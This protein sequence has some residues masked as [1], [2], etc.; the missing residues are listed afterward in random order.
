MIIPKLKGFKINKGS[1]FQKVV[2][3]SLKNY[4]PAALAWLRF[5]FYLN[6]MYLLNKELYYTLNPD[7]DWRNFN[8]PQKSQNWKSIPSEIKI[9]STKI[10]PTKDK[11]KRYLS[12]YLLF[13]SS[14][15]QG[16]SNTP[17]DQVIQP[18]ISIDMI[19]AY[20]LSKA[21]MAQHIQHNLNR[22]ANKK[23]EDSHYL[24]RL[25]NFPY[26]NQAI[27]ILIAFCEFDTSQIAQN[28]NFY[29]QAI[30]A[31]TFLPEPKSGSKFHEYQKYVD[32]ARDTRMEKAIGEAAEKENII[33]L[34]L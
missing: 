22:F 12:F 26:F 8:S 5:F 10:E 17:R 3:E 11:C 1:I 29:S 2:Q 14:S 6:G 30:T 27:A 16:R 21:D 7:N 33:K 24:N 20:A 32:K 31:L 15:R 25:V 34:S 18:T 19:K 9:E 28:K 4:H 23:M 13:L